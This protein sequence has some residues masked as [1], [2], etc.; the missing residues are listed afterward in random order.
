LGALWIQTGRLSELN[1]RPTSEEPPDP[2]V[3]GLLPT[4]GL[5]LLSYSPLVEW[6][7][8]FREIDN[9]VNEHL[10]CLRRQEL[11]LDMGFPRG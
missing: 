10:L 5:S 9:P 2:T 11:L 8:S 7:G 4:K 1:L 3:A 6:V